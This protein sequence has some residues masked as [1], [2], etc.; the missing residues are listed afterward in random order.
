MLKVLMLRKKIDLKKKEMDALREKQADIEKREAELETA[1]AE[2]TNEEEKNAVEEDV[3]ALTAERDA[4]NE[5]MATLGNAINELETELADMERAQDTEPEQRDDKPAHEERSEKRMDRTN[6]NPMSLRERMREVVTRDDVKAYLGEVRTAIKEKRA[7]TNVGLTIPE[8]FLGYLRENLES[9]SK[10]YKYVNVKPIKGE[11]RVVIA[12]AVGEAIW[13]EC[14]ANLNE[15]ELPFYGMEIDCFKVGG[16]F[17]VCNATLEDSDINLAAELV[18][19]IGKAIGLALDKAILFGR[20]TNAAL[21]M[22]M[23]IV[24]RLV[25]TEE[26]SGYPAQARPWVDLHTSNV[27]AI[28]AGTTGVNLFQGL[29][30][31]EG[32]AKNKFSAS[33]KVHVMNE[34]TLNYLKAQGMSVNA[35]GALVTAVSGTMPVIGGQV[36]ILDFIPNNVIISGYFDLYMLAERAAEKF[37]TSEHVKFLADQTV[38]KGTARFDGGPAIAEAFVAIGVNGASVDA[39]AVAFGEDKANQVNAIMLNTATASVAVGAKKQLFAIVGPGAGTVEWTSA[40]TAKATVD[41]YG[42]VT[43]VASGSSVITATCNGLTASCTVTVTTA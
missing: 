26:P 31:D 12:G 1:I 23:G 6:V 32:A 36:E 8:V 35:A 9:Y 25:Q 19:A 33:T 13:T 34:D 39:T 27:K 22:P 38:M 4:N 17:S 28:D 3:N 11:G 18:S 42:V 16:Y 2:V 20:N 41:D 43:G 14:C 24:T 7:L 5:A 21:K 37:A 10:L 30:I 40:T 29:L 15:L